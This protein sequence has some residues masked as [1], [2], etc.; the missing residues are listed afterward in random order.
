MVAHFPAHPTN[1]LVA[2]E[3]DPSGSLLVTADKSG[4]SFNVF[5]ILAHP[6]SCSLGAVVQLYSL[7][8]GETSAKVTASKSVVNI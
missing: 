8:R 1:P 7:H 5:R 4:H 2:M 6:V 3:F